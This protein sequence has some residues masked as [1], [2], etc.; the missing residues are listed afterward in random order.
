MNSCNAEHQQMV[1]DCAHRAQRMNEWERGF[2]ESCKAKLASGG[3]LSA[4]QA[5]KLDE[6]WD[7]VTEKG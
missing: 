2:I 5:T 7:R 4:G 3:P 6:L 1:A